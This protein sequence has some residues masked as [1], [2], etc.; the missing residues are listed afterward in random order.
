MSTL[1]RRHY[2]VEPTIDQRLFVFGI[3]FLCFSVFLVWQFR[4]FNLS[5]ELCSSLYLLVV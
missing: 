5:A 2:L 4:P 3:L 1:K